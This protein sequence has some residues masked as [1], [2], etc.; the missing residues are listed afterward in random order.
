MALTAS[1]VAFDNLRPTAK[2]ASGAGSFSMIAAFTSPRLQT[3]I[4][5]ADGS[6]GF[7]LRKPSSPDSSRPYHSK[8]AP[9]PR[10][11]S[12]IFASSSLAGADLEWNGRD[13][14]G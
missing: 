11:A 1:S 7:I 12:M 2:S 6:F 14:S 5:R 8:S 10:Q 13:E 9:A 3:K 4:G